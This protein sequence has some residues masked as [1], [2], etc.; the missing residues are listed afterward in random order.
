MIR[1]VWPQLIIEINDGHMVDKRIANIG[2]DVADDND[3]VASKLG[4][5]VAAILKKRFADP[6]F[7]PTDE[8]RRALWLLFAVLTDPEWATSEGPSMNQS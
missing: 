5:M 3:T 6:Q 7:R 1:G 2:G 8:Q 4:D